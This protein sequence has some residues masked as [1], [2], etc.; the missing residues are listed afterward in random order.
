M[1]DGQAGR[2]TDER[3]H[4]QSAS[5]T[6]S[7]NS[8]GTNDPLTPCQLDYRK[9]G[10]EWATDTPPRRRTEIQAMAAQCGRCPMIRACSQLADK[11]EAESPGSVVGVWGGEY[12]R[13]GQALDPWGTEADD[14]RSVYKY[15]WY[16]RDRE[17]WR[18]EKT[19][20]GKRIYIISSPDEHV[21]GEAAW[22]WRLKN[23]DV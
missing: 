22:Q 3:A 18:A 16:D 12:W 20:N 14:F 13:E 19:H 23:E 7:Q 8:L 1:V 2:R 11:L 17:G 15:V 5:S 6:A 21:A 9:T 10:R 4:R